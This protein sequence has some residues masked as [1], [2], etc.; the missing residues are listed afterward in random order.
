MFFVTTEI[1]EWIKL[2]NW[3]IAN[4]DLSLHETFVDDEL[5]VQNSY[6]TYLLMFIV[7]MYYWLMTM[8]LII[9]YTVYNYVGL[10]VQYFDKFCLFTECNADNTVNSLICVW[11]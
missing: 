5:K 8:I 3:L 11:T 6:L 1:F 2:K 4:F 7:H 10:V 9:Q